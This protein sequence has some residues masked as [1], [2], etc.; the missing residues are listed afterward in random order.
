L[1]SS[2][3]QAPAMPPVRVLGDS[4]LGARERRCPVPSADM[5]RGR[6]RTALPPRR[7]IFGDPAGSIAEIQGSRLE[8]A[9]RGDASWRFFTSCVAPW[10]RLPR[11]GFAQFRGCETFRSG[12]RTEFGGRNAILGPG[13]DLGTVVAEAEGTIRRRVPCP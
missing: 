6:C 11:R 4:G 5:F 1:I 2:G 12:Q 3:R 13:R 8:T 7:E 9:V 10:P